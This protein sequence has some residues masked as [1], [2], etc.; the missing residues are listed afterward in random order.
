MKQLKWP[1]RLPKWFKR[2]FKRIWVLF[3][4]LVVLLAISLTVFRALT[5][6]AAQYKG[7]IEAH[8][9]RLL[10]A[11]VSIQ[12]M[13]TSW[14]WF[15]PVLKLDGV[16]ISEKNDAGLNVKELLVGIDL[17][18]SF[19]HW[20][21]QPGVL[22][23]EDAMLNFREDNAHWQLDGVALDA[24]IKTVPQ[25][26]YSTVLGWLLAHQKIVMKRVGVTLHWSD[27][28]VTSVK[29]LSV[30][31]S[32]N[33]GHYRVKGHASLVG[34]KKSVLSLLA[35]LNMP[36]GFSS[37]IRG[38]VYLSAEQ[39]DFAEWHA[40]FSAFGFEVT[41]G[42]GELQVW[43]DINN[44]RLVSAQSVLRMRNV[45]WQLPMDKK[46]QKIERLSAN[47]AWEETPTGWKC[48]ADHV[49]LRAHKVT[50]PENA[51]TVTYQTEPAQYRVFIKT[52][53]LKPTRTLLQGRFDGLNPLFDVKPEGQLSHL[54]LGFQDGQLNY[55]LSRFSHLSWTEKDNIPAVTDLSG[56]VA[57]E[58]KEGHLEL[59]GEDVTVMAKDKPAFTAEL[60][61][62]SIVWK[63][64]SHGWRVSL[65]R[66]VLKHEHGLFSG[67]GVLDDFT[68]DSPGHIQGQIAFATHDATFWW[69]YL[70]EAG[71]K[72]K[73]R[74]W[75]LN[76]VTRI[77][78][79]S[80]RVVL[81]GALKDFPFDESPGKFL[82]TSS[83]SGVDLRFNPD[84][85]LTKNISAY[86]QLDKRLLTGNITEA[87]FQGTPMEEAK[88]TVKDLGLNR[89]VLSVQGRLRAP[90][91]DMQQYI[92]HSPLHAKLSKLDALILKQPA[93]L[94]LSI[95]FPFYPGPDSRLQVDGVLY[96][97]EN[98]LFLKEVPKTFKLQRLGGKLKFDEHGVLDS[99]LSS[100]L[101]DEPMT[102][103]LHS[104]RSNAPHLA[105][106][107]D[108]YLSV[109]GLQEMGQLP[110]LALM[111]GR[112]PIKSTLKI[113]DEPGDL[114][115]IH[116][117]SSL[118]GLAVDLPAPFGKKRSEQVPLNIDTYF[119]LKRGMRLQV[120]Y[121]NQV[122][123]DL[124][125]AKDAQTLK[126]ARGA[127][128]LGG[129]KAVLRDKPGASIYGEFKT[130]DWAPWAP[131]LDKLRANSTQNSE[132]FL[133]A[134][135]TM[136]F[137][138]GEAWVLKQHYQQVNLYAQRMPDDV[139]SIA[140]KEDAVSADLKYAP[141]EN[142]LSG[143]ISAWTLDLPE[144]GGLAR[145]D[146]AKA[147][148]QPA[149]IP[150]LSLKVSALWAGDVNAGKLLLKGTHVSD[151][152]WRLDNGKLSS[153]AYMLTATG[154]WGVAPKPET[155]IDARLQVND[156]D[157][158]LT[159]WHISPVVE[160]HE[161]DIQFVGNWEEPP[162][163][164]SVKGV[165]G[166]MQIVFKEGRI[167]NLSP[168]TE[169]KMALG[170]LLSILSLQTIPRRLK[171]DFSDLAKPGYSFDKF[172]GNFVLAHGIMETED[173][174]IDGPVA[175][176]TMKGSLNLDKQLYDLSL[177]ITP[178]ITASLPVVATIAGGPVAGLATWVASKLINQ[179]MEKISGYT[180][181]VSGPWRE[182]VVQQVHIYK[183]QTTA[184]KVS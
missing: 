50:W 55:V 49:R 179:G 13:K 58:P 171:L 154:E 136:S 183:K 10:G 70:P 23:I 1:L 15:E 122:S 124:W 73:L 87:D 11:S 134:F 149:Q 144:S 102:L 29:P 106:D 89:E 76:D 34:E 24:N 56:A 60:L 3:V 114:D 140:M 166:K 47:M 4:T 158:A 67:R 175:R 41:K 157:K 148:W 101:F 57:W 43:L 85:P 14:Y 69:P 146:S 45:L 111:R 97:Q 9:S 12:E 113:T 20:R 36:T 95:K 39:V 127:V 180:Y 92:Q 59:D 19:W 118:K 53:L 160:A 131:V 138:F 66:A 62:A 79:F 178:H 103:R 17:M 165:T 46:P 169:K 8:L 172:D 42:F 164:F 84:W 107:M 54:Q 176:A 86:L 141:S 32:N 88:L 129:R 153:D 30:V 167:P 105:I 77:E 121:A 109:S 68:A 108:G 115:Y 65:E 174:A 94:N 128:V 31:A 40:L 133:Q 137:T 48:T 6:W 152:V 2:W 181:D 35:D 38:Q 173:A 119:N 61:N 33:D 82:V 100:Y 177:H 142:K 7:E 18:R 155:R 25:A 44:A 75:L 93:D 110:A 16:Q 98:E 78:Q 161:G 90:L 63:A 51:F 72:P 143:S 91:E 117:T 130:F 28:R 81:E 104:D 168:E 99:R 27:G 126:L 120:N 150:N 112:F 163:A 74:A 26:E 184:D 151:T 162:N 159:H 71:L 52:L 135:R 147:T 80:G 145:E 139:W 22:F 182:P 5:P 64:L 156:L 21:I 37:N 132:G 116:L 83:M 170:K 123:T 125:L 96:F